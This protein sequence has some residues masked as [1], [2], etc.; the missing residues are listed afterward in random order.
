MKLEKEQVLQIATLA[1]LQLEDEKIEMYSE[2]LSTVFDYINMLSEVDTEGVVETTQV[3]GLEDVVREDTVVESSEEKRQKLI[4]L[5]PEK[6]GD[7][8]KVDAVFE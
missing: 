6:S 7:L 4:A 1:R 3:T 5:F 2:Q 8:L